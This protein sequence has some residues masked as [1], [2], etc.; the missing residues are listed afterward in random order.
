[1]VPEFDNP[2]H[3]R[4][5]GLDPYFTEIV[6]CFNKTDIY[7]VDG[8]FKIK[9]TPLSAPLDPS[10]DKTYEYIQGMLTDLNGLFK[11]SMLHLGGDEID[12][13]CF[14]ENPKINEY[15]QKMN[16]SNYSELIVS[17]MAKVRKMLNNM[18][19]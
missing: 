19:P 13:T 8:K 16:I 4:A 7:Q 1:V 18:S 5:I 12:L 15:M 10:M 11:D 6:R 3:S 17:H 14:D 2:G 9:G